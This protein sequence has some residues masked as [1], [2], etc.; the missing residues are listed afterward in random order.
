MGRELCLGGKRYLTLNLT[1]VS[2]A[3]VSLTFRQGAYRS[4]LWILN[5]NVFWISQ[6]SNYRQ[7][8]VALR[9]VYT[10]DQT[11]AEEPSLL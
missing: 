6:Y 1:C 11:T 2:V 4:E 5:L 8:V 10:L 7:S 3:I 9:Q